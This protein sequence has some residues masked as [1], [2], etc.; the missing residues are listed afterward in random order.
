MDYV[1]KLANNNLYV[2]IKGNCK[3]R[4]SI[5]TVCLSLV[6]MPITLDMFNNMW[7]IYMVVPIQMF[8][9]F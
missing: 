2:A 1:P 8:I 9:D 5:G 6:N 4:T 7:S 3:I